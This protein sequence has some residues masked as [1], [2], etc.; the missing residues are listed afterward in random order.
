VKDLP[1]R[2]FFFPALTNAFAGSSTR[3][4]LLDIARRSSGG[5]SSLGR[6]RWFV[7]IAERSGTRP[8]AAGRLRL[9]EIKER[10]PSA[11]SRSIQLHPFTP[12]SGPDAALTVAMGG[13]PFQRIIHGPASTYLVRTRCH[14]RRTV[15]VAS[16][17]QTEL[18]RLAKVWGMLLASFH[19][20][21]LR[22]LRCDVEARTRAI[23]S[24][25][26]SGSKD[27]ARLAYEL[28]AFT[29][30]AYSAFRKM[31]KEWES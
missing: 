11:L 9:L 5:L 14:A 2:G 10:S 28:A 6:R 23:A 15:D 8:A 19:V 17:G 30:K 3:V 4:S 24:E 16:L 22:G 13:D 27:V 7:L 21:G 29:N 26:A 1:A 12:T 20:R 31:A 18:E 25:A